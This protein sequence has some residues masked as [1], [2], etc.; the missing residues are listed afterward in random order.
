MAGRGL[1]F[2]ECRPLLLFTSTDLFEFLKSEIPGSRDLLKHDAN[3]YMGGMLLTALR[4][5]AHEYQRHKQICD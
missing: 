1:F 4:K 2:L 5:C 3:V